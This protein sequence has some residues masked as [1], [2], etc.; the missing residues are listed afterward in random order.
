[1]GMDVD[2]F[3]GMITWVGRLKMISGVDIVCISIVALSLL[4]ALLSVLSYTG[5][6]L[7]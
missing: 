5:S 4:Q 6:L 7:R 1:M 2:V 3:R